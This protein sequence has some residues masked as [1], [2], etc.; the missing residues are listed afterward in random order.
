MNV[1]KEIVENKAKL[2]MLELRV[3]ALMKILSKEGVIL[4]EEVERELDSIIK[5]EKRGSA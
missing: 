2:E 5:E 1:E 4:E 3:K